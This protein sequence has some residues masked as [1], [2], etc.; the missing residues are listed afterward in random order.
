MFL[1]FEWLYANFPFQTYCMPSVASEL[2]DR[3]RYHYRRKDK[4]DTMAGLMNSLLMHFKYR[5]KYFKNDFNR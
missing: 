2:Q 1:S 5:L 3:Y 4:V